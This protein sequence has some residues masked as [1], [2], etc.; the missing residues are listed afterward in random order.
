MGTDFPSYYTAAVLTLKHQPLRQFYDWVW[1]QRQ[2]HYAGIDHQLRGYIPHTPLTMLPFVPL[3]SVPP[4][5]AKQIWVA[6]ELLMLAASVFLLAKVTLPSW[7]CRFLALLAHAAL[8][9]N[10]RLGSIT[11]C[12]YSY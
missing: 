6:L 9:N 7:R 12:S 8:S 10:F 1:F 3:T 11:S 4:Q 5:R 2:I